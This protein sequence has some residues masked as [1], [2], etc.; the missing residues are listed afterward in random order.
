M[1]NWIFG[2]FRNLGFIE[3]LQLFDS[4]ENNK[5]N[6]CKLAFFITDC[7]VI[8]GSNCP[9]RNFAVFYQQEKSCG[10]E[11]VTLNAIKFAGVLSLINNF[12]KS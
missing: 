8:V 12:K 3:C 9:N 7:Y 5:T 4:F 11:S 10:N 6:R 1:H 2:D